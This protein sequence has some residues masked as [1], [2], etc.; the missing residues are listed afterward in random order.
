MNSC[1]TVNEVFLSS[2][3]S[4]GE[5][6]VVS[7]A[8]NGRN[9]EIRLP[10]SLLNIF[11]PPGV[12]ASAYAKHVLYLYAMNS[13]L[14]YRL[15]GD[16]L[17][18]DYNSSWAELE[19][20]KLT[21]GQF[22]MCFTNPAIM[23]CQPS[24]DDGNHLLRIEWRNPRGP[25]GTSLFAGHDVVQEIKYHIPFEMAEIDDLRAYVN[26]KVPGSVCVFEPVDAFLEG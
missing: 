18:A 23:Q 19:A 10:V 2:L 8:F 24:K 3:S 13:M 15:M 20:E 21:L 5:E 4:N 16:K 11:H 6:F 9:L 17:L 25:N 22:M 12:N 7:T 1:K 14:A 26:Y